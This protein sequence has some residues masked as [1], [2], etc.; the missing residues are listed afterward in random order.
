[1]HGVL[2]RVHTPEPMFRISDDYEGCTEDWLEPYEFLL[3]P[4]E[5]IL[6]NGQVIRA[7]S[8]L[9]IWDTSRATPATSGRFTDTGSNAR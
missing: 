4:T 1:M 8:Y 3:R 7:A 2:Y 5:V 6:E 9:Y